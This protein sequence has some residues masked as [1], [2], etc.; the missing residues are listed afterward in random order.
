MCLTTL[1]SWIIIEASLFICLVFGT[2]L[3][4]LLMC[5][6]L[7]LFGE[8]I[9][10]VLGSLFGILLRRLS[11]RSFRGPLMGRFLPS[12][13][14]IILYVLLHYFFTQSFGSLDPLSDYAILV[15]F[16]FLYC[17]YMLLYV[18]VFLPL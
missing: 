17:L 13:N 4:L 6:A 18:I 9:S 7:A 14:C 11:L 5:H 1:A 10:I 16:P 8:F 3:F 2:L 12:S 15:I